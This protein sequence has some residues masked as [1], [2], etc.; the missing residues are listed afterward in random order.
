MRTTVVTAMKFTITDQPQH[1]DSLLRTSIGRTNMLVS[2]V[3]IFVNPQENGPLD[4][5]DQKEGVENSSLF[6]AGLKVLGEDT[7]FI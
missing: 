3:A 2:S 5:P 6:T 7:I 4:A 1:I